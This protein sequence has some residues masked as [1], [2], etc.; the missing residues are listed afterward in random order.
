M[1]IRTIGAGFDD[2]SNS[3]LFC[4]VLAHFTPDFS[5]FFTLS[6]SHFL[7]PTLYAVPQ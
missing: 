5:R 4:L 1:E 2:K 3:A 6:L 7:K